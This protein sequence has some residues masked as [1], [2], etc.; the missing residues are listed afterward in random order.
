LNGLPAIVL[1][2]SKSWGDES[3]KYVPIDHIRIPN[4]R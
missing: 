4:N 3:S 2:V 1:R